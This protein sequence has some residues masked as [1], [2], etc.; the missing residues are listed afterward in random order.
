MYRKSKVI[1]AALL[2]AGASSANASLV[3]FTVNNYGPSYGSFSGV[4]TNANGYLTQNELTSFLFDRVD[5]GHHVTLATLFGFGDFNLITNTWLPNG[6]G[7]GGNS[8]YFSWNNGDNA[9]NGNWAN[10]STT[11][12][13]LD[14]PNNVPEPTSL[15]LLTLGLAGIAAIRRKKAA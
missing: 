8:A 9:V 7:W 12:T 14:A 2:I 4:D 5:F 6:A 1:I 13:Q 15:A 11:I 10:V 3:N